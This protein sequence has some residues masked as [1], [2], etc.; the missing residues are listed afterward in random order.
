MTTS[1]YDSVF[2]TKKNFTGKPISMELQA[3]GVGVGGSRENAL[4]QMSQF[5]RCGFK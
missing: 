3:V 5:A 1:L 2:D 4:I